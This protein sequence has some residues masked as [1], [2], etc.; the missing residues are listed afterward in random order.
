MSLKKVSLELITW[1]EHFDSPSLGVLGSA[2]LPLEVDDDI[3]EERECY[4]DV[5]R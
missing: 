4:E 1:S 5:L 3:E 2:R